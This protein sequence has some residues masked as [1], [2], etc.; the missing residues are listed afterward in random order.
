M[1]EP[2]A[3]LRPVDR[4]MDCGMGGASHAVSHP[5]FRLRNMVFMLA[6]KKKEKERMFFPFSSPLSMTWLECIGL[7]TVVVFCYICYQRYHQVWREW[8]LTVPLPF[9]P[10]PVSVSSVKQ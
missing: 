3:S 7:L 9:V 5:P 6:Y 8:S 4:E 1:E 2:P 10:A